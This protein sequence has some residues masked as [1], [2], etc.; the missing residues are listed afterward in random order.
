LKASRLSCNDEGFSDIL[1]CFGEDF[2]AAKFEKKGFE[3][4]WDKLEAIC[5]IAR[6]FVRY[7]PFSESPEIA[8]K[9]ARA[10]KELMSWAELKLL[11]GSTRAKWA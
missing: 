4:F 8:Q 10:M 7:V 2:I 5:L 9:C 3:D 1:K 6:P 11:W